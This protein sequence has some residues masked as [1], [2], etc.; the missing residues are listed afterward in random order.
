MTS[1]LVAGQDAAFRGR[2]GAQLQFLGHR[3]LAAGS[4]DE[5]RLVLAAAIPDLLVVGFRQ[6]D[7]EGIALLKEV[8]RDHVNLP[9][10]MATDQMDNDL[11]VAAMLAGAYDFVREPIDPA[12][13]DAVLG[14]AMSVS[15]SGRLASPVARDDRT[16]ATGLV[17]RSRAIVEVCKHIGRVAPTG[18]SVLITGES[19]TGKEIVARAIHRHSGCRGPFQPVNCAAIVDTLLE[20]EL[21]GHE[22]GSF[23]GAVARKQGKF[24]LADDGVL[25]LDEISELPLPLQAKLLRVLQEG[26]FERVGGTRSLHA[27]ARIVAA[28]NR[29]LMEMVQAGRFREDLYY[30]IDVATI[31]LPPLRE[32]LDDLPLLVEYLLVRANGRLN[33][34]PFARVSEAA[35]RRLAAHVWPGNVRELEN[36]L[37][38]AMILARGDVLTPD[39]LDIAPAPAVL[40]EASAA[41]GAGS[42]PL[43]LDDLEARHVASVLAQA[44]WHRGQACAILGI[45]RPTLERKI[46]KHGLIRPGA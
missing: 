23:T 9:V 26:V 17:G 20:S 3:V 31:S 35:M 8:R 46:R 45:S 19:G 14:K 4:L 33:K 22:K 32:H 15:Q 28:S 11:A 6:P 7:D 41:V 25:F 21:F 43:S 24:E 36:V 10:L 12:E 13:L 34:P 2:M 40:A 5:V 1:I 29:N 42:L 18:V 38:R 16:A 30:R 39:L 44:N 27:S 37:L